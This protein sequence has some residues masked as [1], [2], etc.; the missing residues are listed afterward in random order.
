[1]IVRFDYF[2]NELKLGKQDFVS[3]MCVINKSLLEAIEQFFEN[4]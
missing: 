4:N 1:M 3:V 2:Q